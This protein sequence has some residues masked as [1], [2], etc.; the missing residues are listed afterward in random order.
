VEEGASPKK[1]FVDQRD[2]A[3]RRTDGSAKDA[4][5]VVALRGKPGKG[6]TSVGDGL[7]IGGDGEADVGSDEMVSAFVAGDGPAVVIGHAHAKGRDAESVEPAG[8]R[9]VS[10]RLG[11]PMRKYEDGWAGVFGAEETGLHSV[12]FWP[13]RRMSRGKGEEVVRGQVVIGS[14]RDGVE[15]VAARESFGDPAIEEGARIGVVG[16]ATDVFEAP[17]ERESSA[18][19]VHRPATVLVAADGLFEPAH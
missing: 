11:V 8:K 16:A 10:V 7:A 17:G 9:D 19:V 1:R 2:E 13:R 12:V 5:A 18:V 6:A 3:D 4:Q 15:I 14:G